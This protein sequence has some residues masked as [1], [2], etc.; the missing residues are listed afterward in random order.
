MSL[1]TTVPPLAAKLLAKYGTTVVLTCGGGSS[2]DPAT[3]TNTTAPGTTQTV[4]ALPEEY[5]DSLRTLGDKL[6]TGTG[7]LEG[8]KKLTIAALGLT[9]VPTE[10]DSVT[11]KATGQT[12]SVQAIGTQW[13][14]EIAAYYVLH[15]RKS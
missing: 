1:D 13:A 3:A 15:V 2:Y 14:G 10:G 7:T 11:M 6:Q 12:Y 5:A 8:D 4:K 9:T